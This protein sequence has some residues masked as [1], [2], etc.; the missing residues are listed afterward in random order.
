[1]SFNEE[2]TLTITVHTVSNNPVELYRIEGSSRTCK[3]KENETIAKAADT[4]STSNKVFGLSRGVI[5]SMIEDAFWSAKHNGK[6][7]FATKDIVV[8][9]ST[10]PRGRE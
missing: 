9:V 8:K 4:I 6:G 3:G 5:Y 7:G 10:S 1:M 2:C